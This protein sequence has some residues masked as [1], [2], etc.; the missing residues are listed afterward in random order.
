MHAEFG[1]EMDAEK[2]VFI[3]RDPRNVLL[4]KVRSDGQPITQGTVIVKMGNFIA[5]DSFADVLRRYV[6]WLQHA[7]HVVSY[8]ELIADEHVLKGIAKY[9]GVHY[10]HDAFE[11][12]PGHTRTWN[13]EHSDYRYVWTPEIDAAWNEIGGPSILAEW[14]YV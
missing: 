7:P 11:N 13:P 12:L 14:G 5:G 8:E 6:P 2:H 9:L 4:S 1:A 3:K 10:L